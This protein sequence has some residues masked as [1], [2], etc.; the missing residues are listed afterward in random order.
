MLRAG[1]DDCGSGPFRGYAC[2]VIADAGVADLERVGRELL[3]SAGLARFHGREFHS[4]CEEQ[5]EAYGGF[6]CAVR[7]ALERHGE[8]AAF[9]LVHEDEHNA[10]FEGF[11]GRVVDGV[12]TQFLG[13]TPEFAMAK[14]GA[15]F[16]LARCLGEI[17]HHSGTTV[18]VELDQD[19]VGDERA[20]AAGLELGGNH[21]MLATTASD[22]LVRV[23]N[24]YKH[25][26]F[27]AGPSISTLSVGP[28]SNSML[29]QAADLLANFGVASVKS[30][31]REGSQ[32]GERERVR[33]GIFE[34]IVP[35]APL[36]VSSTLRVTEKSELE[37]TVADNLRF[38]LTAFPEE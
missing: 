23:V 11:A 30:R 34:S 19:E 2:V 38:V 37:G 24:A 26:R 17:P 14:A 29:V 18:A 3:D 27:P 16:S 35:P 10:I 31:V 28:S 20:G 13:R 5:L 32:S 9:Q 25:Q 4:G 12:L 6:A 7:E 33:A 22:A 21:G 36:P 1:V 8:Y 15:L